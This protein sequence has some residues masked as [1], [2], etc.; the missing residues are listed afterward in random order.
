MRNFKQGLI[1]AVLIAVGLFF[2]VSV[3]KDDTN[4]LVAIILVISS[5]FLFHLSIR[6]VP[7]FK[8]YFVSKLNILCNTFQKIDKVD[9]TKDLL[10]EQMVEIINES[11]FNIFYK[12]SET[13]EIMA[14]SSFC[15][16]SW[17]ENIYITVKE[18]DKANAQ[19][20]FYSSAIMQIYDW[21][22]NE[23]NY[24]QLVKRREES[25]IV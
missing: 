12:N 23:E 14:T 22:K 24:N 21:G 4:F 19:L 9:L 2:A 5:L 13:G 11:S 16:K 20:E 8:G 18:L 1:I 15:W 10:F 17:G 7:F 25:L 6:K 3:Q